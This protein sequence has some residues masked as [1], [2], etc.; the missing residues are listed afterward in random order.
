MSMIDMSFFTGPHGALDLMDEIRVYGLPR[1]FNGEKLADVFRN[2][3]LAGDPD[4]PPSVWF[5]ESAPENT[6]EI[7]L[8]FKRQVEVSPVSDVLMETLHEI[9]QA[10]GDETGYILDKRNDRQFE[11][12]LAYYQSL[13]NKPGI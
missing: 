12:A 13:Q 10:G 1:N 5:I 7:Q 2:K 3:V 11:A 4:F 9:L 6:C 8:I